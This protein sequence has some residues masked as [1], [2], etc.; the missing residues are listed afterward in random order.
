LNISPL[1]LARWS[2]LRIRSPLPAAAVLPSDLLESDLA[3]PE[4]ASGLAARDDD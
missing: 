2:S 4:D 1:L 3:K